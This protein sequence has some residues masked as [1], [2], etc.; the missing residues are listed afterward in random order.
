MGI[1]E[2]L[3]ELYYRFSKNIE[4]LHKHPEYSTNRYYHEGPFLIS[5]FEEYYKNMKYKI[6]IIGKQTNRWIK[7]DDPN[8]SGYDVINI[9]LCEY[10]KYVKNPK[11]KKNKNFWKTFKKI[12]S[13]VN[14]IEGNNA[15]LSAIWGNLWRY[16]KVEGEK[17]TAPTNTYA[18]LIIEELNL[19]EDEIKICKPDVVIFFTSYYYDKYLERQLPGIK[20][21]IFNENYTINELSKCIHPNLPKKSYRTYHPEYLLHWRPKSEA[22]KYSDIINFIITDI[23][24]NEIY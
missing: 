22:K 2:Q 10:H 12:V 9:S 19:L 14:G 5:P 13:E 21:E 16:N 4:N 3:K 8:K 18:N 15:Y 24:K 1:T 23:L 11:D 6:M 20:H 17:V 7:I